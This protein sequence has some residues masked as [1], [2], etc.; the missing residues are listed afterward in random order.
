MVL[1]RGW[2]TEL[3]QG[4]DITVNAVNPGPVDTEMCRAAG[5]VDLERVLR[6]TRSCRW[7]LVVVPPA[8]MAPPRMGSTSSHFAV[9]NGL[10]GSLEMSCVRKEGCSLFKAP[11]KHQLL[12]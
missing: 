2:A 4:Y 9:M 12:R 10:D 7:Q 3:G 1:T 5:P 11:T 8:D 6:K